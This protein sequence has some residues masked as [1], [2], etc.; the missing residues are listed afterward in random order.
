MIYLNKE[1]MLFSLI[2][3]DIFQGKYPIPKLS[4]NILYKLFFYS[5]DKEQNIFKLDRI[6]LRKIILKSLCI[7]KLENHRIKI[8]K[9]IEN[10]ISYFLS[11]EGIL[12]LEKLKNRVEK[13]FQICKKENI[14]YIGYFSKNYPKNLKKLKDP[15]FIIF[16]KGCF[17]SDEELEKSLA[18]IGSRKTE[19]KYGREV[20]REMGRLLAQNN[21]WNISGL[22]LGCDKY[23]HIGSLEGNGK[24]GAILGQGLAIP[25]YPKEN[26]VLSKKILKTNGF[27][28]SEL[29]P[30]VSNLSLFFILRNRLQSGIT[31]GIFVVQTGRSGGALHTIKYSLK[32]GRKTIIWDPIDIKGLKD[33]DEV[34]G[35][36]ILIENRKDKLGVIIGKDLRKKILKIKRA[37]EIFQILDKKSIKKE[38]VFHNKTLF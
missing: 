8:E 14:K 22:A 6:S 11:E 9:I 24:T 37:K 1:L 21:W 5:L 13:E 36:R 17:P 10:T 3:S 7:L 28:M 27:L 31:Q 4:H 20:A 26:R 2:Y 16:Y 15:P 23:G 12:N 29:P 34:L 33:A 30:T 25:I 18:I 19:K 35:N 32:Q 38:R